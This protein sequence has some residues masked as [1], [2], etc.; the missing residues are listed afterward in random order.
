MLGR[1]LGDRSAQ[2]LDVISSGVGPGVA[3]PQPGGQQL[4]GVVTPHPQRMEPEAALER[5]RRTLFLAVG[6]DDRGIHVEHHHLTEITIGDLGGG[7]SVGQ[8]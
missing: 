7:H 4:G 8:L 2:D 3:R 5:G 6:D 1:D